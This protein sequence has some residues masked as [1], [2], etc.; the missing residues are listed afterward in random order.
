[1]ITQGL[2]LLRC[3]FSMWIMLI[4]RSPNLP[5][6]RAR[7]VHPSVPLPSPSSS[8]SLTPSSLI[9]SLLVALTYAVLI[10]FLNRPDLSQLYQSPRSS[11]ATFPTK[12]P[13]P[14]WERVTFPNFTGLDD[15]AG[16]VALGGSPSPTFPMTQKFEVES[17]TPPGRAYI[18]HRTSTSACSDITLVHTRPSSNFEDVDHASSRT[19]HAELESEGDDAGSIS[20]FRGMLDL[21]PTPSF[22]DERTLAGSRAETPDGSGQLEES[23]ASSMNRRT[24]LFLVWFPLTVSFSTWCTGRNGS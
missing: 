1:M 24:S 6:V 7:P 12:D 20:S 21:P 9:T 4:F 14:P 23:L 19:M 5:R 13:L 18:P 17:L 22:D 10:R 11:I 2:L 8:T 15:K 16:D 3:A